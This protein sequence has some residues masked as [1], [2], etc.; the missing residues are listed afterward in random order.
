MSVRPVP[1]L[2]ACCVALAGGL[3]WLWITPQGQLRDAVRWTEPAAL[4]TDYAAMVPAV[5]ATAEPD[6]RRFLAVLDRPLFSLTRR[7]PL[8]PPPPKP[9]E[10]P[11]PPDNL[12]SARLQA[13]VEV[14]GEGGS[15]ILLIA[16]KSQRVRLNGVVDGWTLK[17]I[18][19]RNVQFE[20]RGQSRVLQ[21]S[22]GALTTYSGLGMPSTQGPEGATQQP[23][24]GRATTPP[25]AVRPAAAA[26]APARPTPAG[27][28]FGGTRR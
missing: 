20:R 16:G 14:P 18:Q 3:A 21:L 13:I 10:A 15:V 6:T 24:A 28:T 12:S 19:E 9:V 22:R 11:P 26:S 4:R 17:S 7:P 8:P 23:A 25:P 27:P 5:P 2:L 1:L